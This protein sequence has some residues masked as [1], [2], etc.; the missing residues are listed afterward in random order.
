MKKLTDGRRTDAKWWQ[1]LTWP[2]VSGELKRT[3]G[4]TTIYKI[5]TQNKDRVT[6][7]PLKTGS[8]LRC[9]GRVSSSCSTSGIS[10]S[11][12]VT[13]PVISHEWG[14]DWEVFKTSGTYCGHLWQIFH[15]GQPS[16][17]CYTTNY[18]NSLNNIP[19]IFL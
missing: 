13:N 2:F 5:Y 15:N 7:T 16:H 8:E 10:H 12:L 11:N 6:Q 4:Q 3:K 17:A 18:G 1:Y 14:K 19:D 9:S